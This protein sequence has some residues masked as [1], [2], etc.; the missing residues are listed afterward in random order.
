MRQSYAKL[1]IRNTFTIKNPEILGYI[2]AVLHRPAY[3]RRYALFLK[4]SFLYLS[5]V[6]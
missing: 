5:L 6:N 1:T 3:R 2:Y 4:I